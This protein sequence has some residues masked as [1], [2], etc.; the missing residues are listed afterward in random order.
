MK[1]KSILPQFIILILLTLAA[2]WV[3]YLNLTVH[4]E[5]PAETP[6]PAAVETEA[7]EIEEPSPTPEPTPEPESMELAAPPEKQRDVHYT[8]AS[9]DAITEILEDYRYNGSAALDRIRAQL[10]VIKSV[11]PEQGAMWENIINY[12]IFVNTD[13]ELHESALPDGLAE[14]DSL[15]IVILGFRLEDDGSMS[16]ELVK[17]CE[18]GLTCAEQYPNA[19]VAVTGGG[20][21]ANSD[22]TEAGVMADWLCERGI[23]RSRIIIEDNSQTTGQNAQYTL[24]L[25]RDYYTQIRDIAIVSSGYHVPEGSLVFYEE[26]QLNAYKYCIEPLNIVSNAYVDMGFSFFGNVHSQASYIWELAEVT[27]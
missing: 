22:N 8:K 16:E 17:R 6:M 5:S 4:R 19:F 12:W 18:V 20:T 9:Y 26:A 13:I 11:D 2:A 3:A 14:D 23:D 1:R 24:A 21:A 15:C 10:E 7:P 27:Y 25:I